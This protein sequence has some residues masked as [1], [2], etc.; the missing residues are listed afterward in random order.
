MVA[1]FLC[2]FL[3]VSNLVGHGIEILYTRRAI[4]SLL[5]LSQL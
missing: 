2:G 3:F 1:E 4:V 5:V